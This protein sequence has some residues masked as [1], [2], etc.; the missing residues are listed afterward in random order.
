M[1][2][3]VGGW[4]D[5]WMGGWMYG[6]VNGWMDGWVDGWMV[7]YSKASYRAQRANPLKESCCT[8]HISSRAYASLYLDW[9]LA[10]QSRRASH[11]ADNLAF[12]IGSLKS[13]RQSKS[14][15]KMG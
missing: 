12:L 13:V 11:S 3:W 6:W 4:M 9:S 14:D 15:S 2:G 5:G 10:Q 1:D 8:F 7:D